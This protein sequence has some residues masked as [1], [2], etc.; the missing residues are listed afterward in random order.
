MSS[1]ASADSGADDHAQMSTVAPG[2][3]RRLAAMLYEGVV[4][5]G[6]ISVAGFLHSSLTQ[7]RHA[8]EGRAGLQAVL[9]VIL[10]LYFVWFWSRGGQT[11]A[12]KTWHLRLVDAHGAPVTQRR[13]VARY[14]SSWLW[15]LPGL[16]MG[17]L[18]GWHSG[19]ALSLAT[20]A[21]ALAYAALSHVLPG[22][23]TPH[24]LLCGTRL[25]VSKP[26]SKR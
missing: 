8:L 10:G 19:A 12:M 15:F 23:Q 5:F 7:Q 6:V 25:I 24:D 21:W 18:A 13:A 4:L 11:V 22:R 26:A 16:G 14:L 20:L 1:T 2:F 17:A 3:W 9:F